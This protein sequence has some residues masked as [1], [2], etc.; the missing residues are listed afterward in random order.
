M[1]EMQNSVQGVASS[2]TKAAAAASTTAGEADT[3]KAVAEAALDAI[4]NLEATVCQTVDAFKELDSGTAKITAV[5]GVIRDIAEQTNLLA[6]NAAIESARAGKQGRGFAVVADA[7][8]ALAT[9]SHQATEEINDI[10]DVLL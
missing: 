2:A 4:Q 5:L 3:G 8:R 9:R 6:L 7:V 10:I 1:N